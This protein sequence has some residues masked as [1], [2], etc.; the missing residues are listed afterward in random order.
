M[1]C[2]IARSCRN[3][4]VKSNGWTEGVYAI[5]SSL[6]R[7]TARCSPHTHTNNTHWNIMFIQL[8]ITK[9]LLYSSIPANARR[10]CLHI[11]LAHC[12]CCPNQQAT[13]IFF[14]FL[15]IFLDA[16]AAVILLLSTIFVVVVVVGSENFQ[17]N[18]TVIIQLFVS[19]C[20]VWRDVTTRCVPCCVYW[21]MVQCTALILNGLR[22]VPSSSYNSA[23]IPIL[24]SIVEVINREL[25]RGT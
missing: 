10:H 25:H 18:S 2:P 4:K 8:L 20:A 5:S 21:Y 12:V 22:Y 3:L 15:S 1:V 13:T 19:S 16:T 9:F 14:C 24:L 7:A 17:I 6:G 23:W 11:S